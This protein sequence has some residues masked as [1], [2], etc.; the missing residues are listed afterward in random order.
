MKG[1]CVSVRGWWEVEKVCVCCVISNMHIETWRF[2]AV[3]HLG[4]NGYIAFPL[5]LHGFSSD[6]TY[7]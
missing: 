1:D 2:E 7:A 3:Q 4:M 5:P 6:V